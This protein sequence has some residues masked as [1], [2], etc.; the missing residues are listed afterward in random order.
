MGSEGKGIKK[1]IRN[2]TDKFRRVEKFLRDSFSM[3]SGDE[4]RRKEK[5]KKYEDD[6]LRREIQQPFPR[7]SARKLF[8]YFSVMNKSGSTRIPL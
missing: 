1:K 8:G 5:G 2:D 7:N 3:D 4:G 6:Y